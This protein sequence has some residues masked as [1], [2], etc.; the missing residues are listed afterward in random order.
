MSFNLFHSPQ[1]PVCSWF[2]G[3]WIFF[4]FIDGCS[5]PPTQGSATSASSWNPPFPSNLRSNLPSATS[6]T[7]D[8]HNLSL[9]QWWDPWCHCHT[10]L[11]DC[12]GISSR[13]HQECPGQA[14]VCAELSSDRVSTRTGPWQHIIPPSSTSTGFRSNPRSPIKS[15]S[16]Q[17]IHPY[18]GSSVN[19]ILYH[20]PHQ[21]TGLGGQRCLP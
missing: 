2:G 13:G 15:L 16:S 5:I 10:C 4:L 12:N 6:E 7:P 18:S 20:P 11:D 1:T 14:P 17:Q 19:L 9:T 3:S 8:S 21:S